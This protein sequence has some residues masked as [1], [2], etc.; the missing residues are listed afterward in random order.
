MFGLI[1]K[2][3]IAKIALE[4]YMSNDAD[5]SSFEPGEQREKDFYFRCGN[6][7]ALNALC[8]KIGINL[9]EDYV[10]PAK[11]QIHQKE[12]IVRCKDC[13]HYRESDCLSPNKFCFRLKGKD[14]NPIGYNF[15]PDDYCSRGE[16]VDVAARK[17]SRE[18]D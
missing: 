17:W 6:A 11:K 16:R 13:V 7:N 2:K 3:K 18:N 5:K 10:V 4:I 9:T 12:S 8:H 15:A 14:G 1:S